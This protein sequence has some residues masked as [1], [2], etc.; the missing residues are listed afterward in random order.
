LDGFNGRDARGGEVVMN[1][2]IEP[3]C[4]KLKLGSAGGPIAPSLAR[5]RAVTRRNG[6]D[7]DLEFLWKLT[8]NEVR[9]AG[10]VSITQLNSSQCRVDLIP[11][12]PG[13]V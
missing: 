7:S 6:Y 4:P 12:V 5:L 9:V 1:V 8:T 3:G 10:L 13:Y 2:G 11:I